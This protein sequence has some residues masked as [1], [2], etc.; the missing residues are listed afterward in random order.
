MVF[1]LFLTFVSLSRAQDEATADNA[2]DSGDAITIT[3]TEPTEDGTVRA[4]CRARGTVS[5]PA[6]EVWL[7][8]SAELSGEY[9]PQPRATI[10]EEGNWTVLGYCGE[11]STDTG[12][13]FVLRAFANPVE[14][15]VAGE[16]LPYWPEAEAT[17][18]IVTV[19]R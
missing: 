12:T 9:W 2:V 8:I 1:I 6:A 4:R 13:P 16:P 3:I 14:P 15:L 5:D 18:D 19:K 17:S 10:D 7:V 11:K